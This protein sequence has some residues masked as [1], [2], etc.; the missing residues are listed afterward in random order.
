MGSRSEFPQRVTTRRYRSGIHALDVRV[1]G[2]VLAA[3][4]FDLRI[5]EV[6]D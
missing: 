3:A 4:E 6:A 5:D 2:Q 1:N